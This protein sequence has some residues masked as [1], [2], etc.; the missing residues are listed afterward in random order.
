LKHT[1]KKQHPEQPA[2]NYDEFMNKVIDI[3]PDR[4]DLH[5]FELQYFVEFVD[6]W[7]FNDKF[8]CQQNKI[9]DT[10]IE[11]L[12]LECADFFHFATAN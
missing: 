5:E 10:N 3:P 2:D 6:F 9:S 1:L 7:S 4:A 11:C 8:T 12:M